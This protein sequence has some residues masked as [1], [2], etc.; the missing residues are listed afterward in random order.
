VHGKACSG[1]ICRA[2]SVTKVSE[3][4]AAIEVVCHALNEMSFFASS[5][6][7]ASASARATVRASTGSDSYSAQ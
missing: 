6:K 2:R 5:S 1:V 3:T 7:A 4:V